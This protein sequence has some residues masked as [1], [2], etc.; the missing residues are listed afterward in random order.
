MFTVLV[1]KISSI[2]KG[3]QNILK[4]KSEGN[5]IK[6]KKHEFITKI[7]LFI[8]FMLISSSVNLFNLFDFYSFKNEEK[9]AALLVYSLFRRVATSGSR[10][11]SVATSSIS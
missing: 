3:K 5:K 9:L 8:I 2:R 11:S 1:L 4:W 7:H 10:N 6:Y